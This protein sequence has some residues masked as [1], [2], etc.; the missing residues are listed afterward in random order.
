MPELPE[1]EVTKQGITPHVIG[2]TITQVIVRQPK[3]RWPVPNELYQL[4]GLQICRVTR[5]AK[6][7]LLH[8][9]K[10]CAIVHLGMSGCIRVLDANINPEKHDHIDLI[11]ANGKLVRYTDPRRF[12]AWLWQETD[13]IHPVF[14][15]LGPEPLTDA[16]N[17]TYFAQWLA[18]KRQPIKQVMMDNA[19]VVGVGNIYANESLFL[20]H[21]H[22]LRPANSLTQAE[23]VLLTAQIKKVL[24]QAIKQGGTTLKDFAQTDGKPGYFAQS[25]FVYG[26]YGEPCMQCGQ[27]LEK[28]AI[29]QR[30]SVFCPHC[31]PI[32]C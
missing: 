14:A 17:S 19:V 18:K 29:A 5:R 30:N 24:R 9:E 8:T 2:Q 31:Q 32:D 13:Q 20:A 27:R 26:R 16:F 7:L 6:Y 15:K 4:I 1:V 28:I 21:L 3:L 25:L 12:G 23:I 11:L 10:G 22:P